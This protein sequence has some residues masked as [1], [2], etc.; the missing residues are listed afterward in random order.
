MSL[1]RYTI[2]QDDG[3]ISFV[4]DEY[5]AP[6]LVAA[7]ATNPMTYQS[8]LDAAHEYDRRPRDEV[9]RALSI[10]DEHNVPDDYDTIHR[11]LAHASDGRGYM[12]AFRI[13]DE[14]TRQASVQPA[15]AGVIIFN[16]KR[17]RIVQ[18]QSDTAEVERSGQAQHHNG[19]GWT[20][21]V[22]AYEL[23]DSWRIVP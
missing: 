20:Q 1:M 14:K 10:F 18:M 3:G 2:V 6:A 8:M 17:R 12:S 22:H 7:C 9:R 19:H 11:D 21:R 23:P 15:K 16:L 4:G 5:M 13:V